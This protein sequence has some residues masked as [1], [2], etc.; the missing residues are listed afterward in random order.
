M[1]QMAPLGL[2]ILHVQWY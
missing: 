1:K 2:L